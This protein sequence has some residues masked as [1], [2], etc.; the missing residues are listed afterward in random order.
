MKHV[1]NGCEEKQQ[2]RDPPTQE[3]KK[4]RDGT[5]RPMKEGAVPT[6]SKVVI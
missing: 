5:Q 1:A 4:A 2:G 3:E 6:A